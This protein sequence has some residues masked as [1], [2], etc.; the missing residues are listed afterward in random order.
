[1]LTARIST[2]IR[3]VGS[4]VK[5]AIGTLF[6]NTGPIVWLIRNIRAWLEASRSPAIVS[7]TK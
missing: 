4:K 2:S 6:P 7:G 3:G 1:M 5:S